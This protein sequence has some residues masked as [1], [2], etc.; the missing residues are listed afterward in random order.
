MKKGVML[1]TSI[2]PSIIRIWIYRLLGNEIEEDV[3]LAPLSIIIADK[4][5][6]KQGAFI[7]YTVMIFNIKTF[8]M[9]RGSSV[10]F[11]SMI[12]GHGG[13]SFK[14]GEFST[15]GL[16]TLVNC[17]GNFEAGDYFGTGPRCMIYTHGNFLPTS[18]GYPNQIADVKIGNF[19]WLHMNVVIAPGVTIGTNVFVYS[20]NFIHKNITNNISIGPPPD[21][22]QFA[23]NLLIKKSNNWQLWD[24]WEKYARDMIPQKYRLDSS[25]IEKDYIQ[26]DLK[27][28]TYEILNN[29]PIIKYVLRYLNLCKAEYFT[30]K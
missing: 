20:M 10:R 18:V 23:T 14:I 4:I 27:N 13:G 25:H 19:V 2:F 29:H 11:G 24:G 30:K 28:H 22:K 5:I 3:Y 26:F 15:L 9:G 16:F 21:C 6:L 17:T 12:Y 8:Q 1:L 7:D